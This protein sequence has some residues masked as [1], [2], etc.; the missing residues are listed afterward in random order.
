MR[1]WKSLLAMVAVVST[2]SLA[3]AGRRWFAPGDTLFS[4]GGGV[5]DFAGGSMRAVTSA[6]AEWDARLTFGTRSW[7]AFEAG[8]EGTYN[9]MQGSYLINHGADGALRINLLPFRVQPFLFGGIGYNHAAVNHLDASPAMAL[10]FR[11]SDDQLLVPAG[12]GVGVY[13]ARHATLEARFTYRAIFAGDLDR[14]NPDARLD[15]WV[16]TGRFGYTF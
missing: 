9:R 13:F 14:V 4:A 3:E 16:A 10:R 11:H 12:A 6:G 7:V 5:A 8:Y 1:D 15:Q 2:T